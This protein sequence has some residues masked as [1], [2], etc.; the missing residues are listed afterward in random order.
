MMH[1]NDAFHRPNFL[2][3]PFLIRNKY[4]RVQEPHYRKKLNKILSRGKIQDL[5]SEIPEFPMT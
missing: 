5:G 3:Q 2:H 4:Y 1:H